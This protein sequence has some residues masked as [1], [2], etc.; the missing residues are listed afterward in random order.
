MRVTRRNDA[1]RADFLEAVRI[2]HAAIVDAIAAGD[3]AL[4][5]RRAVQHMRGGDRRMRSAE[6]IMAATK[7]STRR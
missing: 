1:T 3:P 7:R 6:P 4:A 5:R 2:E